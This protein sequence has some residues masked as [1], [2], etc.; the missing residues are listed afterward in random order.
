[1]RQFRATSVPGNVVAVMAMISM[2]SPCVSEPI[3]M[4]VRRPTTWRIR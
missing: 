1:M 3:I 2:H 4:M